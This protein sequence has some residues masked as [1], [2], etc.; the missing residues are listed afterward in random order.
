MVVL[1]LV[2]ALEE[3]GLEELG[4]VPCLEVMV[5]LAPGEVKGLAVEDQFF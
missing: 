4:L 5:L 2:C 1:G 3:Q